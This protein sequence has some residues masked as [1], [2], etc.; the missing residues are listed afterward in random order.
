VKLTSGSLGHRLAAIRRDRGLSQAELGAAI[1]K[2][3]HT[4]SGWGHGL[5]DIRLAEADACARAL[6]CRLKDLLAP[7]EAPIPPR[8]SLW[9]RMRVAAASASC[10]RKAVKCSGLFSVKSIDK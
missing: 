10:R 5:Y 3:K 2:S 6:H 4:I 9:P 1:G 8:P 7:L